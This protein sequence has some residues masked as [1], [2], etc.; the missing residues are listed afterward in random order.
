MTVVVFDLTPL[1]T[2]SRYRGIGTYTY[3]LACGLQEV[4]RGDPPDFDLRFL[5]GS[6]GHYEL[7]P[8][9]V[10]L[11]RDRVMD[12]CGGAAVTSYQRYY[13]EKRTAQRRYLDAARVSCV[14]APDPKGSSH[15][16]QYRSLVTAHDLIPTV[17]GWPYR[18]YPRFVSATIDRRRYVPPDHVVAISDWTKQDLHRI[19]GVPLE[20]ITVIHHGVE[21]AR[22]RVGDAV[23][24]Q[25]PFFF[26]VGGFDLRKQVPE[27]IRA[28][29]A[30]A[31]RVDADL[32]I[33]G[34]PGRRQLRSMKRAIAASGVEGRVRILGFVSGEELPRLYA[35][36]IAHV[37]PTLYEGFGMTAV[38]AMAAGCPVITLRASCVPEICGDAA[39]YA[40][41]GD[42]AAYGEAMVRLA[43]DPVYRA[44]RVERGLT[45]AASF[46]WRAAAEATL[47][48]YRGV[49]AQ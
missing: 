39:A 10:D 37:L 45:R 34:S 38:E 26:Y 46:T 36:A 28:Y 12:A 31:Q 7:W 2:R 48:V 17:M 35:G 30:I 20:R 47:A 14:H 25:R 40:E 32:W 3:D 21:H 18:S 19:L 4:V 43:T 24:E 49:L 11:S 5:V 33:A 41:P 9:D 27:L 13:W 1:C 42:W 15:R 8:S 29:G 6:G 23:E 44:D 22:Y 16:G